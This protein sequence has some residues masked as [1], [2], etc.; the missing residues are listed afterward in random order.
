[1]QNLPQIWI[2]ISE[3]SEHIFLLSKVKKWDE[4]NNASVTLEKK[5]RQFFE[6]DILRLDEHDKALLRAEG[7]K[8]LLRLDD[9]YKLAQEDR[10][11]VIAES[12]KFARGKR[13]IQA[14]KR[15]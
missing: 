14:Y 2:E 1:M 13:G 9:I 3:L 11:R 12:A 6:V 8:L 7:E 5:I 10:G 15:T 4:I